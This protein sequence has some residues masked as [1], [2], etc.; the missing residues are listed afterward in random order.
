MPSLGTTSRASTIPWANGPRLCDYAVHSLSIQVH[1][2]IAL[3]V[4]RDRLRT[5]RRILPGRTQRSTP[6]QGISGIA[7]LLDHSHRPSILYAVWVSASVATFLK[8]SM[9]HL[10]LPSDG[11]ISTVV[12]FVVRHTWQIAFCA[13]RRAGF[14]AA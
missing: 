14:Y 3:V 1:F 13:S 4:I 7:V 11:L 10:A 8:Y 5:E 2:V 6:G 9:T 12:A